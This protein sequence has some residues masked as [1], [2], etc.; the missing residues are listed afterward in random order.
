MS[1]L[2]QQI[3]SNL[4]PSKKGKAWTIIR[5]VLG[6]IFAFFSIGAFISSIFGGILAV[7]ATL[8][9]VPPTDKFIFN[10]VNN[11]FHFTVASWIKVVTVILLM[12]ISTS[13]MPNT[14]AP[15]TNNKPADTNIATNTTTTPV[16]PPKQQETTQPKHQVEQPKKA[17]LSDML[18]GAF[19]ASIKNRNNYT[20][21][22]TDDSKT[23]VLTYKDNSTS[24]FWDEND[25]VR[26]AYSD[27][28][29][30]GT[31]AFKISDVQA[32]TV[33]YYTNFNDSYGK[34]SNELAVKLTMPK[35]EFVK[36]DWNNL[37]YKPVSYQMIQS[38]TDYDIHPAI[39]KNLDP[40]K[41]YLT[42]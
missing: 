14:P 31:E 3:S 6:V 38:C 19:D 13:L 23:A 17:S 7:I 10:L 5:W 4:P 25:L 37:Y 16:N 29:K 36:Y 20:L 11:K 27:L 33:N 42:K 24:G 15:Q 32:L 8:I 1:E 40:S 30:Y 21:T 2:E 35:D 41:L 34:S 39:S 22:F 18:W 9:M 12:F 28:V 26:H